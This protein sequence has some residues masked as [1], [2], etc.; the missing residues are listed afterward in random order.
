M[1]SRSLLR[2]IG[3]RELTQKDTDG[4][5][6]MP[7][8]SGLRPH[9]LQKG[10]VIGKLRTTTSLPSFATSL[11]SKWYV[12]KGPAD[13]CPAMSQ[14]LGTSRRR[15][16]KGTR[17]SKISVAANTSLSNLGLRT[18]RKRKRKNH[19]L[20][21]SLLFDLQENPVHTLHAAFTY[22]ILELTSINKKT[23]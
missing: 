9:L 19:W 13:D 4:F 6:G 17:G 5:Q 22:N 8:A 16:R 14:A 3:A 1:D 12:S 10:L 20:R 7:C 15:G 18:K 23:R 21:A 2:N 11:D